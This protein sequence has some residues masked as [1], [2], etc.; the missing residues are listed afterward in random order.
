MT[1]GGEAVRGNAQAIRFDPTRSDQIR[2]RNNPRMARITRIV[3]A[4]LSG[5]IRL[6]PTGADSIRP[7]PGESDRMKP[8]MECNC[9]LDGMVRW[10]DCIGRFT[11]RRMAELDERFR[12]SM[13]L[14]ARTASKKAPVIRC[15][16]RHPPA[17]SLAFQMKPKALDCCRNYSFCRWRRWWADSESCDARSSP[18]PSASCL[19]CGA[20]KFMARTHQRRVGGVLLASAATQSKCIVPSQERRTSFCKR[21]ARRSVTTVAS[22]PGA[23]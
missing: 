21:F 4:G 1:E 8:L 15:S 16:G 13:N 12:L 6:D 9:T 11:E 22:S 10:S 18:E 3:R 23:A 17:L 2:L 14:P 5:P 19:A 7:E 20:T